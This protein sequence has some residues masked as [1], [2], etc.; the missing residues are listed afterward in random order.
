MI[1]VL[2]A[3]EAFSGGIVQSIATICRALDGQVAFHVLHGRRPDSPE[4]AR[5]QYPSA[6]GFTP[7]PAVGRS[8]TPGRDRRAIAELRAVVQ[9]VRPDLIHAHSSKAGALVRLA[10]PGGDIPILYSPRGYAF[11]QRDK[12]PAGRAVFWLAER[13][14]GLLPHITVGCGLGEYSLARGVARR[15]VLIPN[16]VDPARFPTDPAGRPDPQAPLRVAMAGGIRPQK[17]F[18][19]FCRI[20]QASANRGWHFVWI[21]DGEIPAG[22]AVPANVEVTGWL[23]RDAVLRTMAGCHLYLQTSLWEGLPVAML[24][25]MIL[26]LPVLAHPAIGNT[27]LVIEGGNGYL[28]VDPD[29]ANGFLARL[30]E[31]DRDR[32][33]LS[34]LGEAARQLVLQHHAVE[35]IAPRWLSLYRHYPRYARH[36]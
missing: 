17:N 8:I 18:P 6:V 31:L 24:E 28:C 21:G 36:G 22:L 33:L 15:V 23:G 35:R 19:L 11:L 14:L 16:M 34:R 20:A 13:A 5:E 29:G 2:H 27:E 26:G 3:V 1:K 9:T 25:A 30:T 10:F 4:D 12:G 32:A 7:W